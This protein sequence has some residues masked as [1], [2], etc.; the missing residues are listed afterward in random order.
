MRNTSLIG[1]ISHRQIIAA[2]TRQRKRLLEPLGDFLRYD[3][4][5]VDKGTFL[6]VQC[7]TGRLI[8]GSIRFLTCSIDSRNKKG[9]TIRR[10]YR[11]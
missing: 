5:I 10:S 7:K 4:V 11:G 9:T 1:E 6:R 8:N 2:L 3:L